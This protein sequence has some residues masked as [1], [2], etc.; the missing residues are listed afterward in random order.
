MGPSGAAVARAGRCRGRCR[1]AP[2]A[3]DA[4]CSA[5]RSLSRLPQHQ[6]HAGDGGHRFRVDLGVAA[7]DHHRA[8]RV[9]PLGEPDLVA[10]G[11]VALRGDGAGVH[12]PDIGGRIPVDQSVAL[13]QE[14]LLHLS[15]LALVELAPDSAEGHGP[16]ARFKTRL[17]PPSPHWTARCI[18]LGR[19]RSAATSASCVPA[20]R[21]SIAACRRILVLNRALPGPGLDV[22]RGCHGRRMLAYGP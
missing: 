16:M 22:G 15:G 12:D 11:A 20:S 8:L 14:G 6:V 19:T 2:G 7:G 4:R 17:R 21:A 9:Q 3:I 5:S 18:V 13:G 1:L 10:A